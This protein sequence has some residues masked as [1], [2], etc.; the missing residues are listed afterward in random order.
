MPTLLSKSQMNI[1]IR[2]AI[3]EDAREI[4]NVTSAST[5]ILLDGDY[6]EEQIE[7]LIDY[8][9]ADFYL[10][11]MQND[12]STILVAETEEKIVGFGSIASNGRAIGDLFLLP[13]YTRQGVGTLLLEPLEQI[14]LQ[15]QVPRLWVMSSLT[16]QPFY[17]SR[18]FKYE[19]DTALVDAAT[20]I[21]IERVVT[22]V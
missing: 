17:S 2:P 10:N 5:R 9:N 14:A 15:K 6:T 22:F 16:A 20:E 3:A 13:E 7:I 4:A 8:C 11:T 18:G 21:K 12:S 19:K 1:S